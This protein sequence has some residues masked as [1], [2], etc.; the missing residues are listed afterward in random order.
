MFFGFQFWNEKGIP[1]KSVTVPAAVSPNEC[2]GDMP[3]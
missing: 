3:L 2:F 1:C